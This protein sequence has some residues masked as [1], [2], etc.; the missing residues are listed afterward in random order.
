MS[1]IKYQSIQFTSRKKE[2]WHICNS[3]EQKIA[4]RQTQ[5]FLNQLENG[6]KY[7][8]LK[9]FNVE[10]TSLLYFCTRDYL[11]DNIRPG[12]D[13]LKEVYICWGPPF[14]LKYIDFV[15]KIVEWL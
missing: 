11:P 3:S 8:G 4:N 12:Y 9:T 14:N 7:P 5:P 13:P 6:S 15:E 10:Q 1:P 2:F